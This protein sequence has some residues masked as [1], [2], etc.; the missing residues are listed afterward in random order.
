MEMKPEATL[1]RMM[2]QVAGAR[3]PADDYVK[4]FLRWTDDRLWIY[5]QVDTVKQDRIMGMIYFAG[6]VLDINHIVIDSLMKC[7]IG[8][9]DYVAQENFVDKLCWMAKSENI[10]IHL[11]H[12]IRKG[13]KEGRIPGKFDIKGT[14]GLT[15]LVDNVF[16]H[17]R[18][19]GKEEKVASG[20][21]VDEPDAILKVDKQRHG[22]WEGTFQLWHQP[23]SLQ[24][25]GDDRNRPMPHRRYAD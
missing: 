3:L 6:K 4:D 23:E 19:K 13:D 10:H 22:E 16:I 5:D 15:D 7:G 1:A 24:F 18:N 14:G 21:M 25:L 20:A 11:V 17:W 8:S 12:H 2:R 9:D